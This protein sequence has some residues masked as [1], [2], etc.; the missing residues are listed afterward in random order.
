[1][2]SYIIVILAIIS[3]YINVDKPLFA[4]KSVQY[5]RLF[6]IESSVEGN[7]T[8]L[9]LRKISFALGDNLRIESNFMADIILLGNL[10]LKYSMPINKRNDMFFSLG[11]FV[12]AGDRVATA[13][14]S[15]FIS[16]LKAFHSDF[17]A[18]QLI[19]GYTGF[20]GIFSIHA[21]LRYIIMPLTQ[22]FDISAGLRVIPIR[23]F[24]FYIET[25][26]QFNNNRFKI[27]GGIEWRP[28]KFF[29]TAGVMYNPIN[30]PLLSF[31]V[32][33]SFDIG[34]VF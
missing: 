2:K 18:I 15:S 14:G 17:Y 6:A 32:V 12:F 23:C 28:G 7:D 31:P 26:F 8:L 19:I 5:S 34:H 27:G 30:D 3:I 9:S 29:M 33:L 16:E 20:H 11:G 1:M 22:M 4:Q 24:S 10:S 13:L 21:N 25:G